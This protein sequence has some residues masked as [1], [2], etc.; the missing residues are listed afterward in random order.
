[1]YF[2]FRSLP[3]IAIQGNIK[4]M[5]GGGEIGDFHCVAP[6]LGDGRILAHDDFVREMGNGGMGSLAGEPPPPL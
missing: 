5:G 6:I 4:M 1:M 2:K 3:L